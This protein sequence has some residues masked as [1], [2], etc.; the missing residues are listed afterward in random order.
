MNPAQVVWV[1]ASYVTARVS[2]SVVGLLAAQVCVRWEPAS[3]VHSVGVG[4]G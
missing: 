3:G 4:S 2:G 1:F